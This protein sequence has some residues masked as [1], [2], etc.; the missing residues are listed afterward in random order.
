MHRI[1]E[2]LRKNP[3]FQIGH[4]AA[5][6]EIV[7]GRLGWRL[8]GKLVS[9]WPDAADELWKR[10]QIMVTAVGS[11]ITSLDVAAEAAG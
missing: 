3:A 4:E 2:L 1:Q 9:W 7:A 10:H 6:A 11:C 8:H 5:T